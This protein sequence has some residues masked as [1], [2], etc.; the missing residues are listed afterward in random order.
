MEDRDDLRIKI[1][2]LDWLTDAPM[3]IDGELV[4][5]FYDAIVRPRYEYGYSITTEASQERQKLKGALQA[6]SNFKLPSWLSGFLD[7]GVKIAGTVEE[8]D[9]KS[10][11]NSEATQKLYVS[12]PTRKIAEL[13]AHYL[14]QYQDRVECLR[15]PL[16]SN[17]PVLIGKD[18]HLVRTP[19]I[20]AFLDLPART[21]LIPTAIELDNGKIELPYR[22][23]ADR[24]GKKITS[25]LPEYPEDV[26]PETYD[27][28][29][30]RKE[31]WAVYEEAFNATDA[32]V[33]VEA[34]AS[35]NSSRIRWIDFRLPLGKGGET[36]HLH[37]CPRANYDA[38]VFGYN[39]IKRGHKH[40]LRIVGT[41]KSEPDMNVMAIYEK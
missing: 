12:N 39:F 2:E 19:R 10:Q 1:E 27:G 7:V 25:K 32:M 40:G 9:E 29:A 15:A 13:T 21:K 3:F 36:M 30:Q 35:R 14:E 22:A 23:L 41:L 31:Y 34:A 17:D 26:D 20:L 18:G 11:T 8:E 38:G 4:E 16:E 28:K 24:W 5:H 6:E 37:V 33:E